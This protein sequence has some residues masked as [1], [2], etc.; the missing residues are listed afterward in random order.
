MNGNTL[1]TLPGPSPTFPVCVSVQETA[2]HM[3]KNHTLGIVRN[4]MVMAWSSSKDMG[5]DVLFYHNILNDKF[6]MVIKLSFTF[7]CVR[8]TFVVIIKET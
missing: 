8:V 7:S 3:E 6:I 2:V 4:V 5:K 1:L